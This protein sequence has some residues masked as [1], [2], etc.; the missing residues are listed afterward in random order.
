[1]RV[2][3]GKGKSKGKGYEKGSE[4]VRALKGQGVTVCVRFRVM[5]G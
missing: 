3:K 5:L 2:S 1:M 4:R